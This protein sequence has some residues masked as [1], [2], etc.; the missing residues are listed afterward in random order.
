MKLIKNRAIA[1]NVDIVRHLIN[2]AAYVLS[3]CAVLMI[4]TLGTTS[5]RADMYPALSHTLLNIEIASSGYTRFSIDGEKTNDAF[6]YPEHLA[7][8][9]IHKSGFIL[10]LPDSSVK[11]IK[12][13]AVVYLT[14]ISEN[15]TV[16]DMRLKFNNDIP[17]PIELV[18]FDLEKESKM[19]DHNKIMLNE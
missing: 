5:A 16:Q 17:K 9:I 19:H 10:V 15:G 7:E 2:L 14:L 4:L 6:I 8:T 12:H 18:V 3:I 11:S 13:K 1:S